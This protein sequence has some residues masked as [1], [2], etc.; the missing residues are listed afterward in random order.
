MLNEIIPLL[1]QCS[2]FI[3]IFI[4]NY[5]FYLLFF[6]ETKLHCQ[7]KLEKVVSKIN[8]M[9]ETISKSQD[10]INIL[11]KEIEKLQRKRDKVRILFYV[12]FNL[13]K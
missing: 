4:F 5:F 3:I 2:V 8:E 9:N 7:K 6:K 13:M 1:F 12:Y 10:E 11:D